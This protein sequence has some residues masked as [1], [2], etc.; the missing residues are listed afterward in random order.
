MAKSHSPTIA[1][2][3]D[4]PDALKAIMKGKRITKLEW[5]NE[6]IYCALEN[7]FVV[8]HKE[9]GVHSWI[10]SE[11]DLLGNDWVVLPAMN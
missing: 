6:R 8:I 9:T 5:A 11:G 7:G 3:M 2:R 10:I 1:K 4:L